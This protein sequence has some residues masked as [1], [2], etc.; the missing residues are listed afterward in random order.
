VLLNLPNTT[1]L[2]T[3][4]H[5]VD[6]V[7]LLMILVVVLLILLMMFCNSLGSNSMQKQRVFYSAEVQHA[8]VSHYKDR[9]APT[10]LTDLI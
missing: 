8:S 7:D 10:E 5:G 3:V 2:Y 1:A 6:V 9:D 4:P